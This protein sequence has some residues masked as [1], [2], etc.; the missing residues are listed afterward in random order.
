MRIINS[1]IIGI[2]IIGFMLSM[3]SCKKDEGSTDDTNKTGPSQEHGT[4][5]GIKD[6]G[7]GSYT[8]ILGGVT[9]TTKARDFSNE[10]VITTPK[11]VV[12]NKEAEY[13]IGKGIIGFGIAENSIVAGY[14]SNILIYDMT[15][16]KVTD[17]HK[18][19][20]SISG[21]DVN[22]AI[23]TTEGSEDVNFYNLKNGKIEKNF[24]KIKSVNGSK[25]IATCYLDYNKAYI[26]DES[27]IV[28]FALDKATESSKPKV[29]DIPSFASVNYSSDEKSI[30]FC[31][32]ELSKPDPNDPNAAYINYSAIRV[33]DRSSKQFTD[34]NS[35]DDERYTGIAV[36]ANYIYISL[37]DFNT[38]RVINKHNYA[39]AGS[40]AVDAPSFLKKIGDELF[41]Y[42][43]NSKKVIKYKVSFN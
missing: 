7:N 33:Y 9:F 39:D 36:D 12:A 32:G 6:N 34:K 8:V 17:D 14:A 28:Y 30:Y 25:F 11:T 41:V 29:L 27:E 24:F 20:F 26:Y 4:N 22:G 13:P 35:A 23:M 21:I 15:S 18:A 2:A 19:S 43:S 5:D 16:K 40:F 37:A 42:S 10:A 38:V 3:S 31:L 1:K